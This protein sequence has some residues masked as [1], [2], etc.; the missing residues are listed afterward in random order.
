VLVE[1]VYYHYHHQNSNSYNDDDE[2]EHSS[3]AVLSRVERYLPLH[4]SRSSCVGRPAALTAT[5]VV[6]LMV[7]VV[8]MAARRVA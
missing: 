6:V 3:V 1:V 7:K 5:Y 2:H 4:V 8:L